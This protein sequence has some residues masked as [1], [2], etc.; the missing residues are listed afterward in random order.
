VREL[1]S[2]GSAQ[3]A[4]RAQQRLAE[5]AA[6][7]R[8]ID[9]AIGPPTAPAPALARV[10]WRHARV[11]DSVEI[12]GGGKGRLLSLP[13]PRGRV[14]VGVGSARLVL[15][16]E[17]VGAAPS[18]TP[19]PAK[20]AALHRDTLARLAEERDAGAQRCDLRGLRVDEALERLA[21]ALDRALAQGSASLAIVHGIGT[22]A[23]RDAVRRHLQATAWV[24]RF[25][26]GEPGAGGEGV[27]IAR[28]EPANVR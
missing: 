1:Q 13:D 14:S 22:G 7:Q 20:P 3:D 25:D 12:R 15:A 9:R 19:A 6:E 24:D 4:T 16:M 18:A 27:T 11:G 2:G 8:E 10:D 28:L 23:L 5:L 26:P 21:D 17:L